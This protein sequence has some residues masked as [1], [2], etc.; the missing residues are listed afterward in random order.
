MKEKK[1][2]TK[3]VFARALRTM[4]Q[5]AAGL[6]GTSSVLGE[7][8]WPALLSASILAGLACILMGLGGL[9][10]VEK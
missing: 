1:N 8:S 7:V 5:T 9:P 10:E 4:V 2:W 6:L 3:A